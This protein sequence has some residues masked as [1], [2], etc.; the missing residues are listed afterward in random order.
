MRGAASFYT[1]PL[2]LFYVK[3]TEKDYM[4]VSK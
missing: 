1:D 2:S 4:P 3:T